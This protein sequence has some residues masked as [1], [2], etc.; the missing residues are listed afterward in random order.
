MVTER[1]LI[2]ILDTFRK[3]YEASNMKNSAFWKNANTE[4]TKILDDHVEQY[5]Y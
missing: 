4:I 5:G 1:E 3:S 2:D